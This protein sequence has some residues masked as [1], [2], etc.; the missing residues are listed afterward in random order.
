MKGEELNVLD[1][2]MESLDQYLNKTACSWNES[3]LKQSKRHMTGQV[4]K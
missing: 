2:K 4:K 3:K 1:K